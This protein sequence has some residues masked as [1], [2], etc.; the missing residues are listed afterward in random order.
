MSSWELKWPQEKLKTECSFKLLGWQSK[1]IMVYLFVIFICLPTEHWG[2]HKNVSVRSRSNWNL[3]V[4]IF[5]ERGKL[6]YPGEKPLGARERT[7]NKLNPLHMTL[8]PGFK[9]GPHWWEGSALTTALP[10]LP[11][12]YGMQWYFLEWSI[13]RCI[14]YWCTA[15]CLRSGSIL[16]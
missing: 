15:A 13:M 3:K 16:V 7:N 11:W 14:N 8:T 4:L 2:V 10:L 9:L 12:P 5:K 1:S 6:E